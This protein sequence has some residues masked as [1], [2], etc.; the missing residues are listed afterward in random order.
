MLLGLYPIVELTRVIVVSGEH[1]FPEM[2]GQF[3]AE[4]AIMWTLYLL[5]IPV[6]LL[7]VNS[8]LRQARKAEKPEKDG[9]KEKN[10]AD[11]RGKGDFIRVNYNG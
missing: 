5:I 1:Y 6:F 9:S 2:G 7:L 11:L 4:I 3:A 10:L 8:F